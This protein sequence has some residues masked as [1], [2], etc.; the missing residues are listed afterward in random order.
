V[1]LSARDLAWLAFIVIALLAVGIGLRDPWPADEPRFVLVAKQMVESGDWMF[2]HRGNELYPDKPPMYMWLL[3]ASYSVVGD[4]RIAFLL[5]SLLAALGTLVVVYDFARRLGTRRAAALAVLLLLFTVQFTFQSKRAQI[6]PTV[7][8]MIALSVYALAR[9]LLFGP[10]WRW[11]WFGCFM[12]GIGTVTKGV[13]FIALL[14]LVPYAWARW[15]GYARLAP[16]GDG[17]WRWW[18]GVPAFLAGVAVWLVPMLV[19][20]ARSDDP[21]L[22]DYAR[23]ILLFQTAVRYAKP[24]HH[25]EPP[26]YFAGVIV[27]MWWPLAF[28]LPW[29]LMAWKRRLVERR[30]GR[31]LV[32]LGYIVLVLVFFSISPG[33]REVY[34]MPALPIL[35]VALAPLLPGIV[36][37]VGFQRLAFGA[38]VLLSV[39]GL[40]AGI[41][42]LT[43]SPGF[44]ARL[45]ESRGW[46]ADDLR[47]W[48]MLTAIGAIGLVALAVFRI[49]RGL[50]ALL[51][52]LA[53]LWMLYA[54]VG[55]PLINPTS[56]ARGLMERAGQ[57]IGPEA[58]LALI[59][60]KEQ[61][62]LQADRPATVFGFRT[63]WAEQRIAA[64]AWLAEK[65][66]NRF[67]LAQDDALGRCIRREAVREVGRANRRTW[68]VFDHAAVVPGCIDETPGTTGAPRLMPDDD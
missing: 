57:V 5:P 29:A 23:E 34:I 8:F 40:G 36:R 1:R 25:F 31:V 9:H 42:A 12:A 66:A 19:A 61:N 39:L 52:T 32:L 65:P 16:V 62:L 44:E 14:V 33:K 20:V 49:R 24:V 51:A 56:S 60:W 17:G 7:T 27:Q 22:H 59:G 11:F 30:D 2:P 15:R 37:R 53:G 54:L 50:L 26:W 63:D 28:A 6:D 46:A 3:A 43:G 64:K 21:A 47:P 45:V 58:E 13:G 48:W 55:Y 67:V 41:A 4:W 10:S 68:V 38:A 35:A 18:A